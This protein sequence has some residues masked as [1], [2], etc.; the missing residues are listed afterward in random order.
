MSPAFKGHTVERL[1]ALYKALRASPQ[2]VFAKLIEPS[3]MEPDE[4]RIL[5]I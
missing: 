5:A 3:A 1:F 4:E 2:Q